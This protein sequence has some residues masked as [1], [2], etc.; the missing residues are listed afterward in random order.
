MATAK[1]PV[2]PGN[3]KVPTSYLITLIVALL[4][5]YSV[6]L[7]YP[8][9]TKEFLPLQEEPVSSSSSSAPWT[10]DFFPDW[11]LTTECSPYG[12]DCV[13]RE[14]RGGRYLSYP[15]HLINDDVPK[16]P[17]Q[18]SFWKDPTTFPQN[19]ERKKKTAAAVTPEPPKEGKRTTDSAACV[20]RA[21]TKSLQ[22]QLDFLLPSLPE[23]QEGGDGG[24][25]IS[26][27]I[28]DYSYSK[29][30]LNDAFFMAR[31]IMRLDHFFMVAIDE[32]TIE[33]ACDAGHLVLGFV[34]S[35]PSPT[36]VNKEAKNDKSPTAE[37]G[38]K[39]KKI[40]ADVAMS[41]WKVALEIL[42]R[43]FPVFFFEMDVWFLR[44]PRRLLLNQTKDV[45][46][47]GHSDNPNAINIGVYSALPTGPSIEFFETSI[48]LFE[49]RPTVHD[50]FVMGQI[51]SWASVGNDRTRMEYEQQWGE[52]V[53]GDPPPPLPE[54]RR[55]AVSHENF[56]SW[57]IV[58]GERPVFSEQTVAVHILTG[59]P[60]TAPHGKQQLAKELGA[61]VGS[62][63][64]YDCDDARYLWMDGHIH[65]A[66]SLTMHYQGMHT[67]YHY[68]DMDTL[69]WLVS[70]TVALANHT[71]RIWVMPKVVNDRGFNFLWTMLDMKSAEDFVRIRE[72]SFPSNPRSW[73]GP[74]RF[75][76]VSRI[77][78]S[79]DAQRG[80]I[81]LYRQ[82]DA[83]ARSSPPDDDDTSEGWD[84]EFEGAKDAV[85]R[86]FALAETV[87]SARV[88]LA[89]LP[90]TQGL[91]REMGALD[92][93]YSRAA[94]FDLSIPAELVLHVYRSLKWC[95]HDFEGT[96]MEKLPSRAVAGDDCYGS[97]T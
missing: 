14:I 80:S 45:V 27:T 23:F 50:Q 30:M 52:D 10:Q 85:G 51:L 54:F 82:R 3:R 36:Q 12:Q 41:K 66:V 93:E 33:M 89:G 57:A 43:D 7:N 35:P 19:E 6:A 48:D 62:S 76:P 26:F 77:A 90:A 46:F 31:E 94:E 4:S 67:H 38:Y 17:A 11:H 47:S 42:K 83:S 75:D 88:L 40:V 58:S 92:A 79:G 96:D 5:I 18:D 65:N 21:R 69:K 20:E 24:E 55:G 97:G 78:I 60:L 37:D 25:R 95:V 49:R 39:S 59:V 91:M 34:Y 71:D 2:I 84:V 72:T 32:A 56:P 9:L 28:T 44:D 87:D 63:G 86:W 8:L 70:F 29:E 61:W 1:L 53:W 68:H 22:E 74:G 64:Y 73:K 13:A 15:F 16:L 81:Q